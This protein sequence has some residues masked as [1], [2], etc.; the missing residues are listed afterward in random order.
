MTQDEHIGVTF[1]APHTGARLV[2]AKVLVGEEEPRRAGKFAQHCAA[3]GAERDVVVHAV[4][5]A[6]G[7]SVRGVLG[8]VGAQD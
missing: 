8:Q 6:Y 3:P 1:S 7:S 5:A 4:L 2:R